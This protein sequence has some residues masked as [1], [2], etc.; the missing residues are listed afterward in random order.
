MRTLIRLLV[1]KDNSHRR[2]S[3]DRG[4]SKADNTRNGDDDQPKTYTLNVLLGSISVAVSFYSC[5]ENPFCNFKNEPS[6]NP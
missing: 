1:M 5:K 2:P 3:S 6:Q 4:V